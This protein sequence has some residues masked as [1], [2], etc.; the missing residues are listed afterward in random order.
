MADD[1]FGPIVSGCRGDFDFTLL[2]EQ[3]I[4]SSV[5]SSILILLVPLRLFHLRRSIVK[6]FPNPI[7]T[8]KSVSFSPCS[9]PSA[10]ALDLTKTSKVTGVA[11]IALQLALLV[12][13]TTNGVVRTEASVP[14]ATLA[15][16]AAIAVFALSY[17]EHSRSVAPSTLLNVYLLFS[18]VFDL[19]QARTL[20][21][22][23]D[24]TPIAAVFSAMIGIKA[25]LLFLESL[26]KRSYLKKPYRE[27]PPESISGIFN[28]S[29]FW[30]LN[31]LFIGGF[32]RL[33]SFDDLFTIDGELTS[34]GL[35]NN[36]QQAW[37]LRCILLPQMTKEREQ[38]TK[39]QNLVK[40]ETRYCLPLAVARSLK[41]P[42][43]FVVFPRL[44]L[45]GFNYSQPFLITRALNFISQGYDPLSN[46]EGLGLIAATAFI[47]FGIT[48]SCVHLSRNNSNIL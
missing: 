10:W 2:F 35:G 18:L 39:R 15:F 3:S 26:G 30:W 38:D 43:L 20:Y 36:I 22:R 17:V 25:A 23:H 40:P 45:I 7:Q 42:L 24:D 1:V 11:F 31:S 47:Y 28:Q 19:V 13:W 41:W 46:N 16:V 29:F 48:V 4:L 8:A 33:L 9:H 14:S 32:R 34:E 27:L 44:C 6:T 12:L 21:L 5:P 37:D